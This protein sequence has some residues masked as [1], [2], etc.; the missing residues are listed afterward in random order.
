MLQEETILTFAEA[1]KAL[2]KVNGKR[3]HAATLWRWARKGIK[4]VCLETR[5]VGGRFVTSP[6]ALERFT[7]S[8]AEIPLHTP[9]NTPPTAPA[10]VTAPRPRSE[11]Q[12]SRD[13]ARA[14]SELAA[15]GI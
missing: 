13:I 15:A 8:L 5:R 4:G 6:E 3:P 7:K 2:P 9:P 12:R 11:R 10:V 14:E 1:A